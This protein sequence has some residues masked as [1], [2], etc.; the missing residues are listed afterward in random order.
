CSKTRNLRTVNSSTSSAPKRAFLIARRPTARRPTASAPMATAPNA[1][2]PSA[3][4]NSRAAGTA[5]DWPVSSRAIDDLHRVSNSDDR[6]YLFGAV[7]GAI[8]ERATDSFQDTRRRLV[9]R[10]LSACRHDRAGPAG[11]RSA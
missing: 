6:I 7:M 10:A 1:A 5:L 11:L 4:A 8:H 2:A 9:P 3:S